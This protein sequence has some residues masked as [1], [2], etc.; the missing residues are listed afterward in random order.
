MVRQLDDLD[1]PALLER[2]R[3]DEA[4]VDELRAGSGCSP[5]SGGGGARG[6]PARRRPPRARVPVGELDRLRAEAHRAAEILD[7]LLLGQ[8]VDHRDTASRDPSRSSSRRRARRRGARTRRPRRACR[9]RCRGTGCRRSRATRQAR[10]LPSQPREPKPPGTS[11]PSTPLELARRLLERHV[12]GVD[13][14]HAHVG[15]RG[16]RPRA[17]APRAPRGTRRGASRT[18]RRARSRR[19]SRARRSARSA[20]SHSPRSAA[21]ARR[22]RAS[23]RRARRGPRSCSARRHEVDVAARPGTRS[24]PRRRRRR[25]ARSCRGCRARAPRASGRRRCPGGY[26]CGAAR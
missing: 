16:G 13:P 21:P 10:I 22:A 18:C 23:R 20:S 7:L 11:T 4:G 19:A 17:S 24:P 26:R 8:Q 5:R 9:G 15:S 25:R 2:A 6:R 3:D 12:L 1:E 14:A